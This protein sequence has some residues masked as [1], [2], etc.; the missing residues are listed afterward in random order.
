MITL[1]NRKELTVTF[2]LNEQARIRKVLAEEGI[3]YTVKTVNRLNSS[4]FSS[5]SRVR[6]GTYGQNTEVMIEYIIYVKRAEYDRALCL[7]QK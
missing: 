5:G 2:D 7:I 3:D 6:T 1:F 4:P